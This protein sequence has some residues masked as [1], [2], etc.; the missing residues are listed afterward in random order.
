ME[1]SEN[2]NGN[3]IELDGLCKN[4]RHIKAVDNLSLKVFKGDVY[5]FLGP[6]GAGKSTCIR[7][8]LSLIKPTAGKISVFGK[9]LSANKLGI[10]N[11]IGALI[12]RPD[13]YNWLSA[14]KNLEILGKLSGVRE[15][16]KRIHEVL[17]LVGLE[18]RAF[19]K[20]KT[21]SQGMKQRLGLAQS[22]LH[23]PDL[24]ILDEPSNGLDPQGQKEMRNLIR[25]IN[26]EKGITLLISSHILSEVEHI[27]NRMVIINKGQA[28]VE[29][30]VAQ[31]LTESI[32]NVY[33]T[34]GDPLKAEGHIMH[35]NWSN[36][37][38]GRI[39][40]R[41]L[42]EMEKDQIPQLSDFFSEQGLTIFAIE[43]KRSLEDYFISITEHE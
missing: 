26:A 2:H 24:I 11:R 31:L 19:S 17:D 15:L 22:L 13:F 4:F 33:Y 1:K 43:P 36:I 12:E 32:L 10:L 34:L 35:S 21:Y 41:L 30:D 9:E 8:I 7:M 23:D 5:G 3:Y 38:K 16:D 29:G 39:N 25:T 18:E 37:F 6:N 20:V 27:A 28:I 14:Y 42:F 40:G